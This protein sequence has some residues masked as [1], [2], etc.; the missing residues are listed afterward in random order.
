VTMGHFSR[1]E[2]KRR[3]AGKRPGHTNPLNRTGGAAVLVLRVRLNPVRRSRRTR[4]IMV[5]SPSLRACIGTFESAAATKR[6]CRRDDGALF[7]TER[8]TSSGGETPWPHTNPLHR[9]GGTTVLVLR[10]RLNPEGK[11]RISCA[12]D[13]LSPSFRARIGTFGS[14]AATTFNHSFFSGASPLGRFLA[15]QPRTKLLSLKSVVTNILC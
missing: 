2:E 12:R 14:A 8:K 5:L 13:V 3:L 6:V 15:A 11:P 4:A 7:K 1:L 9:T 10:V